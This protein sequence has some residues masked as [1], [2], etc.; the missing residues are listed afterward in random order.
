MKYICSICGYVYDETAAGT[1]FDELP[2]SWVCPLC[3]AA[4]TLF[5]P[6]K[7]VSSGFGQAAAPAAEKPGTAPVVRDLS[8]STDDLHQL[9]AGELSALCSNLARGCE[10][11]YKEE[12]AGLFREIAGYFASV[13]PDEPEADLSRL[14]SLFEN[15]LTRGYPAVRGA[16][17]AAGDRGTQRVCVWGQK[18]TV[19]LNSLVQRYQK[20]GAAFLRDTQIWVCSVCGFV[21][22]GDNPPELC[23]VCKVPAWKFDKTEGR[24]SA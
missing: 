5:E 6:E 24:H 4:K 1:P 7:P 23:P 11:Q 21:Y 14:V 13:T 17:E 18:V 3:G 9:S 16:A 19:I 20:E 10:K 22:V 12:E 15:D 8:H 2:D